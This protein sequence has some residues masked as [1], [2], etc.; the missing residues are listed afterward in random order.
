[1]K[2]SDLFIPLFIG[3]SNADISD[4]W[5]Q[6]EHAEWCREEFL[7]AQKSLI[8]EDLANLDITCAKSFTLD[9]SE[10]KDPAVV[11]SPSVLGSQL[12]VASHGAVSQSLEKFIRDEVIGYD[13]ELPALKT[14]RPCS[15]RESQILAFVREGAPPSEAAKITDQIIAD[16]D[17]ESSKEDTGK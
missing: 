7:H 3:N 12:F 9:R 11:F 1:M 5:L 10:F 16:R 17:T 13:A 6:E 2:W 14:A 4:D 8:R 15:F